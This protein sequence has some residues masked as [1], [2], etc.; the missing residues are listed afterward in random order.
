M[1]FLLFLFFYVSAIYGADMIEECYPIRSV[2]CKGEHCKI[3]IYKDERLQIKN[4]SIPKANSYPEIYDVV[5]EMIVD[6]DEGDR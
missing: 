4:I 3:Q 1:K 2:Q 6:N 5:C